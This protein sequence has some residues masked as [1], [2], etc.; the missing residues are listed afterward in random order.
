MR[1]TQDQIKQFHAEGYLAVEN[2]FA[3][4]DLQPVIDEISGEVD[5]LARELAAS[6][7][8]SRTYEEEGF[9]TRLTKIHAETDKVYFAIASGRLS[10]PGI[11]SS[12]T[13]PKLLDLVESLVGP[14]IIATSIYRLRPKIPNLS[15]G[16]VPWHQDSGFFE[17]YCDQ[18]LILTVWIPMVDATP[19]R[20]C[21]QVIPRAH[22]GEVFHHELFSPQ[23]ARKGARYY[24]IP[25]PDL[26]QGEA[27]TVPI[28][29]G[30]VLLMTNR[31]PH[32]SIENTSDVIRWSVDLR[33]QSADLPTNARSP[34]GT[35][36]REPFN[37]NEPIACYPPEAD[38]LVRSQKRPQDVITDW[39]RF[40]RMRRSHERVEVTRRWDN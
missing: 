26:P 6:G 11:F 34:E 33:Y 24:Y 36:I 2:V 27:V 14:E 17:P 5:R 29:K 15:Y 39:Q 28:N 37:P 18:S 1:L 8:L 32:R 38:F 12:L 40:D 31:T 20:G 7:D 19:E 16:V 22:L 13:N 21:M 4:E 23:T 30:G 3:D 35:L 25:D 10:G 9:L